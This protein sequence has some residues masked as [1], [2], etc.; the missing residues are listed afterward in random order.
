MRI[1]LRTGLSDGSGRQAEHS[2]FLVPQ[3]PA[4]AFVEGGAELGFVEEDAAI[5]EGVLGVV[6]RSGFLRGEGRVEAVEDALRD[7]YHLKETV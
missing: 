7:E 5:V 2:R 4:D 3:Q 6:Q 1:V